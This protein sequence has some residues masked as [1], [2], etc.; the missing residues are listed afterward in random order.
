MKKKIEKEF[1]KQWRFWLVL[2]ITLFSIIT[3]WSLNPEP[4]FKIYEEVCEN[5][6][7]II[8]RNITYSEGELISEIEYDEQYK[9]RTFDFL[10]CDV[11]ERNG[12]LDA[13]LPCVLLNKE[14][15][16]LDEIHLWLIF[17]A[18]HHLSLPSTLEL[19][20]KETCEQKEVDE[21]FLGKCKEGF[22]QA[23]EPSGLSKDILMCSQ[24]IC[25]YIEEINWSH[26]FSAYDFVVMQRISK[27]DLTTKFLDENCERQKSECL[28]WG[29]RDS[30]GISMCKD[31]IKK[32]SCGDK[33][34]VEVWDQ[35][36]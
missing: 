13:S 8:Y 30:D 31:E 15:N 10:G 25:E 27:Q 26:C 6:T 17:N 28:K 16:E 5:E 18:R 36:K 32:Y 23:D 22:E 2:V 33:Y 29:K 7:S 35:W 14:I 34:T 1:Y 9:Y 19:T 12:V 21:I 20:Q 11:L 4:H 3:L 24:E